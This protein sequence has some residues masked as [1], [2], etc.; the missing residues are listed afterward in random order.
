M[1]LRRLCFSVVFST[2]L[3]VPNLSQAFDFPPFYLL[4]QTL[5]NRQVEEIQIKSMPLLDRPNRFGHV[6]GNNVRR[7]YYGAIL[8]NRHRSTVYYPEY[9]VVESYM[10]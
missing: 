4:Q 5:A 2:F 8:T 10:D 7:L 3:F 6:Y 9:W 1:N